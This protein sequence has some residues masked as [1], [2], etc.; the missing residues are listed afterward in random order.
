MSGLGTVSPWPLQ[1]I[2]VTIDQTGDSET[3]S[4]V[5]QAGAQLIFPENI[6]HLQGV[7]DLI[8]QEMTKFH[9]ESK[10]IKSIFPYQRA[11]LLNDPVKNLLSSAWACQRTLNL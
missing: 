8:R 7:S 11:Q 1:D 5:Y 3:A 2:L 4:L 9:K 10:D 6:G